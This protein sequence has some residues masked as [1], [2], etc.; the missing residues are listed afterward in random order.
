MSGNMPSSSSNFPSTA[1]D[2]EAPPGSD[3]TIENTT[4]YP[5]P[6]EAGRFRRELMECDIKTMEQLLIEFRGGNPAREFMACFDS[7]LRPMHETQFQAIS[8]G[9]SLTL[10][11]IAAQVETERTLEIM[12]QK[13]N[14]VKEQEIKFAG[15]RGVIQ[16]YCRL[17]SDGGD[18]GLFG[19]ELEEL[20]EDINELIEELRIFRS[21][22]KTQRTIMFKLGLL[23][24]PLPWGAKMIIPGV[25]KP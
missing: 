18:P 25:D 5:S 2:L 9:T 16:I 24:S 12:A 15:W 4:V 6:A 14:A 21:A 1:A 20:L 23:Q 8:K 10:D 3:D 19:E 7:M 22:C 11:D 13:E 17:E